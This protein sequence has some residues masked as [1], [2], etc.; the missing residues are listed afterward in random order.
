MCVWVGGGG[1]VDVVYWL[2]NVSAA[3]SVSQGSICSDRFT[4]FHTEIEVADKIFYLTHSQ[5]TD[6]GPISPIA[7]HIT[8]GDWQDSHWSTNF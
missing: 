1:G 3:Y 2:L 6:S 7:T 5:Y 8:P 4:C